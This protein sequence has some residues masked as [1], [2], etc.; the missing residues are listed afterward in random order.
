MVDIVRRQ[1][2]DGF[3]PDGDM[4]PKGIGSGWRRPFFVIARGD[5]A[6]STAHAI[7]RALATSLRK[8]GGVPALPVLAKR[9][10]EAAKSGDRS[11]F[12]EAARDA[13]VAAG[14]DLRVRLAG[15]AGRELLESLD[16]A[17]LDEAQLGEEFATSTIKRIVA[18]EFLGPARSVLI[19]ERFGTNAREREFE[20]TVG[21]EV[22]F[23]KFGQRL[24]R[25]PQASHLRAPAM[26]REIATTSDMLHEPI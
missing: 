19:E 26:R 16:T 8:R 7:A 9:F 22:P 11:V 23:K 13:A 10:A 18:A 20:A 14:G 6:S 15:E 2:D 5:D 3:M 17:G 24:L 25:D 4:I 12:A 1:A 21:S